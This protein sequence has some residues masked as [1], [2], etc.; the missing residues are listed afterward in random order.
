MAEQKN[1]YSKGSR[2]P[3]YGI[4]GEGQ[5]NWRASDEDGAYPVPPHNNEG[6]TWRQSDQQLLEIFAQ[7]G[8]Y[9]TP[10]CRGSP[11]SSAKTK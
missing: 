2:N 8:T 4:K 11:T 1:G 10:I 3:G 6:P 7:E 9:P 5:S